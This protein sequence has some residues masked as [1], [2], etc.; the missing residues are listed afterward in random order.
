[1]MGE[2]SSFG[3]VRRGRRAGAA[4]AAVVSFFV[5]AWSVLAG[6]LPA[7]AQS[8][9]AVALVTDVEGRTDPAVEPFSEMPAGSTVRLAQGATM[10]VLFYESCEELSIIGAGQVT[11][12]EDE[13]RI[14]DARVT[15]RQSTP[16]PRK[17]TV[18]KDGTVGGVL[19]RGFPTV[20]TVPTLSPTPG[21]IFAGR[22]AKA[23]DHIQVAHGDTVVL[24]AKLTSPSFAWPRGTP[25][26]EPGI[27]HTLVLV[28]AAS[29]GPAAKTVHFNFAAAAPNATGVAPV[30]VIRLEE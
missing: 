2:N 24:D 10:N 3:P 27:M 17:V 4:R 19:I 16:C 25:P 6:P 7:V 26:L 11:F 30:T 22:S 15:S 8:S 21:F 29:A 9:P 12:T 1:M 23:Y 18:R 20:K 13:L 14:A 28:P 5:A